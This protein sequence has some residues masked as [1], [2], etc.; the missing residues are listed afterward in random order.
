MAGVINIAVGVF[1]VGYIVAASGDSFYGLVF[2]PFA[3]PPLVG[4]VFALLRRVWWLAL[5]GSI[6]AFPPGLISLILIILSYQEFKRPSINS[7]INNIET[8]I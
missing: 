8:I 4:G 6:L 7:Q 1:A 5:I 2:L 3:I